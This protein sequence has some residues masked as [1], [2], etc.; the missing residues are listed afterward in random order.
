[1]L[2][3]NI[4]NTTHPHTKKIKDLSA[5]TKAQPNTYIH[6]FLKSGLTKDSPH[7]R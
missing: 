3:L 6:I 4:P 1:M 5:T 2:Q 7:R